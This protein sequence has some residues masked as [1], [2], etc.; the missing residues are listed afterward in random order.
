MFEKI[1]LF[2]QWN[3]CQEV[4]IILASAASYVISANFINCEAHTAILSF[5]VGADIFFAWDSFL[6]SND[7]FQL[8]CALDLIYEVDGWCRSHARVPS[9]HR[10]FSFKLSSAHRRTCIRLQEH[11]HK[12]TTARSASL[13]LKKARKTSSARCKMTF[14][15]LPPL[16]M[17]ILT[18]HFGETKKEISEQSQ[19]NNSTDDRRVRWWRCQSWRTLLRRWVR[20]NQQLVSVLP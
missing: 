6:L 1:Y 16:F 13:N 17:R 9:G 20:P 19:R 5:H 14:F 3:K 8:R 2:R 15:F 18:C 7:Q 12:A 4:G 11:K 10:N